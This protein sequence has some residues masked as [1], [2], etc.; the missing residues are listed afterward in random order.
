MAGTWAKNSARPR[1]VD[2]AAR[3]SS[4]GSATRR[5][6]LWASATVTSASRDRFLATA[7]SQALAWR[8]SGKLTVNALISNGFQKIG[9]RHNRQ[10]EP[11]G[12][13]E[14]VPVIGHNIA[15]TRGNA[16]FQNQF[17][18][19]IGQK[20]ADQIEDR[21]AVGTRGNVIQKPVHDGQGAAL[22]V[23]FALEDGFILQEQGGGNV[24]LPTGIA[25]REQPQQLEGGPGVG[26]GGGN[27]HVGVNHDLDGHGAEGCRN[28]QMGKAGNFEDFH[29]WL[30]F[31]EQQ[32]ER[33]N[34]EGE[35]AGSG[36]LALGF[37]RE[38]R[39]GSHGV[40][41]PTGTAGGREVQSPKPN[42]QSRAGGEGEG[43][44]WAARQHQPY[45]GGNVQGSKS[46]VQSRAGRDWKFE[47][48]GFE[49][50]R[51]GNYEL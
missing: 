51:R 31:R 42:V 21:V 17:V 24:P 12:I 9:R 49:R 14:I 47:I 33:M 44:I 1:P 34:Y 13:P 11:S 46:E 7:T 32:G 28:G 40:T 10:P 48:S 8:L 39:S 43:N 3:S 18:V 15:R 25:G 5:E 50:S 22:A 37:G 35:K 2:R 23:L 19:G 45:R 26:P 4:S 20:R 6:R 36:L 27:Q 16:K 29:R 30:I 41:R 38:G